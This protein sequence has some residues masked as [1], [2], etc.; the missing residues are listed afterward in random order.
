MGVTKFNLSYGG[1]MLNDKLDKYLHEYSIMKE[2]T[3]D[4]NVSLQDN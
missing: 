3:I 1:K 2:S 4:V